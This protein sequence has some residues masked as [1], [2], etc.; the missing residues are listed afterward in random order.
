M[1]PLAGKPVT[2]SVGYTTDRIV[3]VWYVLTLALLQIFNVDNVHLSFAMHR[4]AVTVVTAI[5]H[6]GEAINPGL[7]WSEYASELLF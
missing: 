4:M 2:V 7:E 1:I 6:F 5:R 3:L